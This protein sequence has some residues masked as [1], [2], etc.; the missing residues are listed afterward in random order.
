MPNQ[1]SKSFTL[2]ELLIVLALISILAT[3]LILTINPGGIFSKARDTKRINDLKNIEKIMDTLYSTEYT[4][5]ELNY[6]STNVIYISLPD[7]NTNCSN[8]LSQLPSLPSGWSYYCSATPTNIDGT[9]WIPIPFSN[10]PILNISQLPIDPINKPPYY[11][12]FVVGGSYEV[13]AF[14]E[15]DSSRNIDG[16]AGIDGGTSWNVYEVGSNKKLTPIVI[17]DGGGRDKSL[18]GYWPLDEGSGNIA[19]DYSGNGYDGTLVNDPTWTTGKINGALSFDGVNDYILIPSFVFD[20]DYM[21]IF[22]WVRVNDLSARR[23]IFDVGNYTNLV[24][25]LE[26]GPCS[27]GANSVC[28]VTPGTIQARTVNNVV[29]GSTWINIVYVKN[30]VGATHKIYVNGNNQSLTTNLS[31]DYDS[32]AVNKNIGRRGSTTSPQYFYGDIDEVRIY[33]RVL[34]DSEIKV[35]YEATK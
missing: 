22:V 17:E 13:T 10:F 35:L 26:V 19:K 12:S 30:G 15:L 23:T 3:I 31:V 11:Y 2:I 27:G 21:T 20:Y 33:N 1:I 29:T 4:F 25:Q 6:A 32:I 14:L 7:N 34:S 18:V 16:S 24:S 28:V 9:G 8:W 5:N